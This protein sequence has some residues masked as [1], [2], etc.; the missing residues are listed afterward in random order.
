MWLEVNP[1]EGGEDE[2]GSVGPWT[3]RTFHQHQAPNPSS[4]LPYPITPPALPWPSKRKAPVVPHPNQWACKKSGWCWEGERLQERERRVEGC[5]EGADLGPTAQASLR[6]GRGEDGEG[7]SSEGPC[8]TSFGRDAPQTT[9]ISRQKGSLKA[10]P[11]AP[12]AAASLK[13]VISQNFQG[14]KWSSLTSHPRSPSAAAPP[15]HQ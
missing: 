9:V 14:R 6:W 5:S 4:S 1:G 8:P 12:P 13:W 15:P 11:P 10:I 3:A 7:S 2:E